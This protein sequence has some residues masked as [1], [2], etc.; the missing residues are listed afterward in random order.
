MCGIAGIWARS[1]VDPKLLARM[2]RCLEHRGP[3]GSGVWSD[4]QSGIGFAHRRLAIVDLSP[5]GAQPMHSADGRWVLSYNGEIYNHGEIR[6]ELEQAGR[7]PPGGWRGH[8]DTETI[9]EAIAAWGLEAALGKAVGMFALSLWDRSERRL[10]LARDRFGEKPLYYGRCGADFVFASELKAIRLHPAFDGAIDRRAV[11][12]LAAIAVIPAPL[13]IYQ[14]IAKLE[15]GT[16]LTLD[17]PGSEP[18]VARYW[19]YRD[20]VREDLRAPIATEAEALDALDGALRRSLAGQ[21]VADVPIGAFLSGGID[22]STI[23]ALYQ[24]VSGSR[25]STFSIGFDESGYD[26]SADARA[27]AQHLGTDHHEHRVGVAEAQAVIPLLPAIYDEPFADSSQIPTYL[28]SQFARRQVTVAITGD[29][30]DE[31]FAGYNRHRALPAAWS[32]LSLLPPPL[33]R[34]GGEL[35]GRIPEAAWSA[36][37]RL[38]G[39]RRRDLGGKIAKGLAMAGRST[40]LD[41][42]RSAF[43]DE[44]PRGRSPVLGAGTADWWSHNL[45]AGLDPITRMTTADALGYLPDDILAKVDRASM[46][47]SLETRV[48]FLDHRVAEVAAQIPVGLKVAG[49]EG[50]AILRK[51][52]DRYV[53]RR[54][55][56]RPKAG[57]AVPVGQ[58]I[59][60]PLRDWA[61]DL[62]DPRKLAQG[63]YFDARAVRD[64]WTDHL[65]GRDSTQ[66]IWSVLMFQAWL[67][68]Q[69]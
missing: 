15:P 3:D 6:V 62:L 30:G 44:W 31:L 43:L 32:R 48:P 35:A 23:V 57:F 13:S 16:I 41:Q 33:R 42:F 56:E 24:A 11:A 47:V 26:E 37:A 18:R 60:G 21:A 8:S 7:T 49:G 20:V 66:A 58:W 1:Q 39:Q 46:A 63:G 17:A 9:L 36:L 68:E 28:V 19:S 61:E 40:S 65:S 55:V 53:P 5:S 69:S 59:R 29:G 38:G 2:E 45:P 27:V 25:V 10:H 51:L 67:A 14:G 54:L 52:L 4:P 12:A 34:A 50:K 64:R 22:S